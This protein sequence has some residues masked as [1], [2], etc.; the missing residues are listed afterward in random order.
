LAK[1]NKPFRWQTRLFLKLIAGE[2]PDAI[3]LPTGTGKTGLM[4]IWLI[5]LAWSL[6]DAARPRIPRRLA[7]IV[8]R[9]VVVDQGTEE[10]NAIAAAIMTELAED[11]PLRATLSGASVTGTLLNVSTLR[12]EKADKGDWRRDPSAPAII[13]GTVDMI[14]SRLLFRGYGDGAYFRPWHAG[15]LG[16]DTLIVND[17]AHLSPAFARLLKEIKQFPAPP[18]PLRASRVML[19]SATPAGKS[20]RPFDHSLEED[21]AS[22]GYFRSVYTAAKSLRLHEV[23]DAKSVSSAIFE[24]GSAEGAARTIVFVEQPEE[25]AKLAG[26][27]SSS[28]VK[29][30]TGTMRGLERDQLNEDPIFKLFRA[31]EPPAEPAWLIATSAGEVGVNITCERLITGLVT[32]DHLVQRFGRLARFPVEGLELKGEAIVV[33]SPPG[34]KDTDKTATLEFLRGLDG[35]VSARKLY[36]HGL[37]PEACEPEPALARFEKRLIDLWSL[38]S[39][40]GPAIPP[41]ALW[42]HG[43]QDGGPETSVAWRADAEYLARRHISKQDREDALKRYRVL[44]HERLTEPTWRIHEK[45]SGIAGQ[46]PEAR[47]LVVMKDG[48]I[49]GDTLERIAGWD[50]ELKYAL[51]LLA[52][53]CG[54]LREG[55]LRPERTETPGDDVADK[56]QERERYRLY[57][58]E[59]VWHLTRLG[60]NVPEEG[61][62]YEWPYREAVTRFAKARKFVRPLMIPVSGPGGEDPTEYLMYLTQKP[63]GQGDEVQL[64]PHLEAVAKQ[65]GELACALGLDELKDVFDTAGRLHD[66]GK[67]QD[68]WQLAMRG[69]VET[70]LLAK[71]KIAANPRLLAGYRHELES[72]LRAQANAGDLA[73]HLI[74]AHHKGARP[75]F[76]KKAC[77]QSGLKDCGDIARR[78]GELQARWGPW[79]LAYLEAL[80]KAADAMMS[81]TTEAGS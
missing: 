68:L 35:D 53:G 8:N 76:S 56:G 78:F 61:E 27:F 74:A 65:A 17:E 69:F 38:T 24:L 73:L 40:S 39:A 14:G 63:K 3:G 71:T 46:L 75:H 22:S 23:A 7:W 81:N 67:D 58:D 33:Y 28:R 34:A 10:A 50:E 4:Q 9:R 49:R 2:F 19:L 80:L 44:A 51:V 72:V 48:D 36:E 31:P 29:L 1:G 60:N 47:A 54:W 20:E 18:P 32:A 57:Q 66:Q 30:L 15:L 21:Q 55:I 13:V 45:L 64:G 62:A 5:A 70:P 37:P 43:R 16:V 79:G 26:R 42:L 25:A 12:G 6:I 52:P 77:R 41:V 59:D 11:D